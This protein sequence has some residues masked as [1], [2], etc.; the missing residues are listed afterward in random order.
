MKTHLPLLLAITVASAATAQ[1]ATL[2]EHSYFAGSSSTTTLW[3]ST[4]FH[5]Q[6][7]Y[8]TTNLTDQGVTGSI[9]LTRLRFR[10]AD[11]VVNAGG[12]VYGTVHVQISSCP[13]NYSSASTTFNSNRGLDNVVCYVGSVTTLPTSGTTPNDYFV[14]ITLQTPFTFDP[15]LNK[16]LV[17]EV[18]GTA[19]SGSVPS[20]LT[21]SLRSRR[22]TS[23]S[24][25]A[26]TGTGSNAAGVMLIDF[27]GPGGWSTWSPTSTTFQGTGCYRVVNSFYE[28]FL[29]VSLFDLS[30]TTMTLVPNAN[31]G[32]DA[33][34]GPATPFFPHG[35]VSLGLGDDDIALRTLPAGFGAGL[36]FPTGATTSNITICSNGYVNLGTATFADIAFEPA[37]LLFY[38]E[39]PILAPFYVD[40]VPDL[41]GDVYYDVDPAGTTVYVTY[42]NVDTFSVGGTC[43]LQIVLN[44]NGIIE[45]RY[46]TCVG[47]VGDYGIVGWSP[48]GDAADPG[49]IDLSATPLVSTSGPDQQAL[50]LFSPSAFV[51]FLIT[52]TAHHVP[53]SAAFTIRALGVGQLPG[54]DLGIVGG[55]GCPL[56]IDLNAIVELQLAVTNPDAAFTFFIPNDVSLFGVTAYSQA[57]SFVATANPLGIITSNGTAMTIGNS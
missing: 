47:P 29:D 36:P 35:P 55:A 51:N 23:S 12:A 6:Q 41:T 30:N 24:L 25:T 16:D 11:T 43:N 9:Q 21:S 48:A 8:D 45:Y 44:G 57:W 37:S 14:D 17:I 31:G 32:Y 54:I 46:G 10:A 20:C 42:D 2:P 56:W 27:V 52:E 4:A 26:A 28:E 38:P 7:I 50:D 49:S 5:F 13:L 53:A 40:L 1:Q 18:D 33:F 15:S 19:P 22:I 3:R 34:S 39:A